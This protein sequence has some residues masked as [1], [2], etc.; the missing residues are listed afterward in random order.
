MS[1]TEV[2]TLSAYACFLGED[3][4]WRDHRKH[5]DPKEIVLEC[6]VEKCEAL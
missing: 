1:A 5:S 2:V 3:S 6:E 4:I